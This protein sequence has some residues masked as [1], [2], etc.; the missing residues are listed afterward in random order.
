MLKKALSVLEEWWL[1]FLFVL[2]VLTCA[3]LEMFFP[4]EEEGKEF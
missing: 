2:I 4:N 1:L 3:A